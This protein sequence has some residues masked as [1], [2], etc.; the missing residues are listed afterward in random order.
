MDLVLWRHAEAVEGGPGLPDLE[1]PLT[2]KG[3][4]QAARM[5]QWLDRMLPDGARVLV[6]PAQRTQQTA[7]A[8]AAMGRKFKTVSTL[9]PEADAQA[10]LQ[11]AGWPGGKGCVVVVGHQ[12]TL[13]TVASL[14]I[15][16]H[17]Q[18]WSV[19]KGGVWWLRERDKAA[20]LA[21]GDHPALH[22]NHAVLVA[23]QSPDL[24]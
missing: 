4:K 15:T 14:I 3:E 12:P 24:L 17:A 16:G 10:V 7:Q 11:A 21:D 8:L 1:R 5:A 9:A 18:P 22:G 19:R 6:S 13:G 20:G 2:P 23:V